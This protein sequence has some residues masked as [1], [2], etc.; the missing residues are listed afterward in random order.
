[1]T[2]V[3]MEPYE[4]KIYQ[5]CLNCP[6]VQRLAPMDM[7]IAV[8]FGSATLTKDGQV[9]YSEPQ[10]SCEEDEFWTV[11]M[12][13]AEALKDPDHDWRITMFAPLRDREYQRHGPGQWVLIAS[14]MGFA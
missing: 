4:G 14:G 1:M 12:A 8:G 7:V 3:K 2:W 11:A 6:P 10:R 5:G 13:E 9:V